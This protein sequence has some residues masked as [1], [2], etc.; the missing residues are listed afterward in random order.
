MTI[1]KSNILKSAVTL[2][3]SNFVVILLIIISSLPGAISLENFPIKTVVLQNL[4]LLLPLSVT[5]IIFTP[6]FGYTTTKA[7]INRFLKLFI[8]GILYFW[9][10]VISTLLF[11]SN[12]ELLK[13]G[14][15]ILYLSVFAMMA[16]A[17]FVLP[18][19]IPGVYLLEKWTR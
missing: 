7:T 12:G 8:L 9:V 10:C 5:A 6:L 16:M 3:A 13:E 2:F 17:L 14:F 11:M 15:M 18:V 4:T 19:L 1:L